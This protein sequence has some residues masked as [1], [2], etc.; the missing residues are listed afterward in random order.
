MAGFLN[1]IGIGFCYLLM[2]LLILFVAFFF[3]MAD[4]LTWKDRQKQQE[5][6]Q[7]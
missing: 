5:A 4:Y 3:G 1:M 6:R 2:G 7:K